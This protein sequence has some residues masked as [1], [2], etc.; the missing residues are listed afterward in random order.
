MVMI[1]R[2]V[3]LFFFCNFFHLLP[4]TYETLAGTGWV[5]CALIELLSVCL[6]SFKT[7]IVLCK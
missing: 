1:V 4:R 5:Y 6:F 2:R 7:I 3:Y